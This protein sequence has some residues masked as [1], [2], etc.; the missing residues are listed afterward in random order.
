M[1]TQRLNDSTVKPALSFAN[2]Q[3][4]HFLERGRL[5]FSELAVMVE[6]IYAM[7]GV[8]GGIVFAYAVCSRAKQLVVDERGFF[9]LQDSH[10]D[11]DHAVPSFLRELPFFNE[12]KVRYEDLKFFVP[13]FA[14]NLGAQTVVLKNIVWLKSTHRKGQHIPL[15]VSSKAFDARDVVDNRHASVSVPIAYLDDN[16]PKCGLIQ[17]P[18]SV[19]DAV[20][21]EVQKGTRA[22]RLRK[23]YG[24]KGSI[25][26]VAETPPRIL[27]DKNIQGVVGDFWKKFSAYAEAI[28]LQNSKMPKNV[29]DTMM[30][31]LINSQKSIP[32]LSALIF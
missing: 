29:A 13:L 5:T 3:I 18:S 32:E 9:T 1:N 11:V 23:S 10:S 21:V 27:D 2:M 19:F 22:I 7:S 4:D 31:T 16:K 15:L 8:N 17:L 25:E 14:T 26:L 20:L 30:H 12:C 6:A 24:K 28:S